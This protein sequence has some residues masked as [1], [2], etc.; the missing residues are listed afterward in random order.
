MAAVKSQKRNQLAVLLV[1]KFRNKFNVQ[2]TVELEI[3]SH[4]VSSV[5][6]LLSG[7]SAK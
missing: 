7:A 2:S 1:N 6:K 3:D 5:Q 4:I